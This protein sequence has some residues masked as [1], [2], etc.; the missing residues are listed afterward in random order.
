L[1]VRLWG[2]R[3]G[4]SGA[5][6]VQAGE[7]PKTTDGLLPVLSRDTGECELKCRAETKRVL[8]S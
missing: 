3:R 4:L 5:F 2:I 8:C 1:Y 7:H 6:K